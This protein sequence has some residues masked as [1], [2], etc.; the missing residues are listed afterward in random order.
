MLSFALLSFHESIGDQ[1]FLS[2]SILGG[3]SIQI[4][5]DEA[6]SKKI[7]G[8]FARV[9][10]DL[11]LKDPVRDK[12]LAERQGFAFFASLEYE[13]KKKSPSFY[14]SWQSICHSISNCKNVLNVNVNL[15]DNAFVKCKALV[16][17]Y[18]PKKK[19]FNNQWK[20]LTQ[21]SLKWN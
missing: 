7:F 4:A 12:I 14:V 19:G 15:V 13:K 17:R 18:V 11:D 20:C 10:I 2:L 16:Q 8:N 6:T 3:V 5:L 1:R 21:G 9:V